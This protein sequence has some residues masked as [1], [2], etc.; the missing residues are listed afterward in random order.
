[1]AATFGLIAG[2][3]IGGPIVQHLIRKYDLKPSID[4]EKVNLDDYNEDF[5]GD[6]A[7]TATTSQ[8]IHTSTV[9]VFC[10]VVGIYLGDMFTE[11]TGFS[12]SGYVGAMF[13]AV[14]VRNFFDFSN[15]KLLNFTLNYLIW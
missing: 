7:V 10:M 3:L 4:D 11:A 2:G 9:I 8:F 6:G 15:P 1:A 14:F 12:L 13:V 5:E